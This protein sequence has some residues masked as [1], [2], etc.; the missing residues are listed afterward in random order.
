MAKDLKLPE[1]PKLPKLKKGKVP[2]KNFINIMVKRK[3]TFDVKRNLP[4]IIVILI[5][6]A[7]L[8]KFTMVD[9]LATIIIETNN[10]SA[11]Q[12]ELDE[13]NQKISSMKEVDDLYAHYTTSGMTEEE[14]GRVDRVKAMKLIDK[15]FMKGNI[16][17]SWN[18]TGNTM[19]LQV[20]GPS[21][22]ELNQVAAELEQNSIV[23]RCVIQSANKRTG[24]NG[25]VAVTFIIYLKQPEEE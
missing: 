12:Q 7:V 5:V 1:L 23:E 8:L 11:M 19:T 16:S 24:D 9:R 17:K 13:A 18:L 15:S 20:K 2:T 22:R 4:L 10:I 14:L 25:E 21:L 6:F 3:Q